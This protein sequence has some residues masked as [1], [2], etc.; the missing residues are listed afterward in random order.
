MSRQQWLVVSP[1][2]TGPSSD[3]ISVWDATWPA[4]RTYQTVGRVRRP[5][6]EA[7]HPRDM[8]CVQIDSVEDES[9][10][11]VDKV[12]G[13]QESHRLTTIFNLAPGLMQFQEHGS[14][15]GGM[16]V[17]EFDDKPTLAP[18]DELKGAKI[19][20][21]DVWELFAQRGESSLEL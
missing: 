4:P 20:R 5:G 8:V 6:T 17:F 14:L 2:Y 3:E 21:Q 15:P 18:E 7:G 16:L 11:I 13:G 1:N 10:S 9:V 12:Y 19:V